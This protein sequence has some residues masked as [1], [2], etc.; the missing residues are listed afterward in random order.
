MPTFCQYVLEIR[1]GDAGI[2]FGEW[3]QVIRE[4]LK[5]AQKVLDTFLGMR[6]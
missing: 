3:L 6:K 2:L 1:L 5:N 4:P